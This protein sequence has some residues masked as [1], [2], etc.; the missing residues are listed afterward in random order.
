MPHA[1]LFAAVALAGLL[2][3]SPATA[4]I[5][6]AQAERSAPD[7]LSLTWS[8]PDPVDVYVSDKPV[9][10]LKNARLLSR[11]DADGRF[12]LDH[13]DHARRYFLLVDAKDHDRVE[14]A[15]RLVP[16]EQGS[17]FRDVGGYVGAGGKR[18]RWGMIYRSGG[19]PML[20]D[21]DVAQIRA[22]GI[23]Q[24]VDLRSSEERVIAP[25]RITGLP[26]T[27]VG[28]SMSDIMGK[29]RQELRNGSDVYRNMPRLLAPQLKV[30][31][32]DLLS[33]EA[34]LAYNC[35]A[36][37][38][39][40]GFT[41][42]IIL[43]VLGVSRQDIEADYHLSTRYRRPEFEMP[44]LDA[45][46]H[47]NDPAVQ[48]FA[49]YRKDP[50]WKTPTPLKDAQGHPF[51]DGAFAEIDKTWGSVD[52]YLAKEIG[53]SHADVLKLRAMYLEQSPVRLNR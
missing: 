13:Q 9:V 46:A 19:S 35:S 8:S 40:T 50:N 39:R 47:P 27:A 41:T 28:Y 44:V 29:Q 53:V 45:A 34:P 52:A 3:H 31:F 16:L 25:S 49:Q 15:E 7:A 24:L 12:T 38:D 17:N 2:A 26:V 6:A 5:A 36:G 37:Q 11:A 48:L 20:T 22:L 21:A 10:A 18:V 43:T 23:A 51:L 33:G 30:I 14:V 4:R 32:A 1:K 42:A